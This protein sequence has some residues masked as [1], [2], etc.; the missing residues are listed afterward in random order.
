MF[1]TLHVYARVVTSRLHPILRAADLL[2][3]CRNTRIH[4]WRSF[5]LAITRR[6]GKSIWGHQRLRLALG[7]APFRQRLLL[8][9]H[10]CRCLGQPHRHHRS[11]PPLGTQWSSPQIIKGHT[12]RQS[13][14][15]AMPVS[16]RVQGLDGSAT[17]VT[18]IFASSAVHR[19]ILG[20]K[21]ATRC[22]RR[23]A[24]HL[25]VRVRRKPSMIGRKPARGT[26]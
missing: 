1:E 17:C 10:H 8:A 12:T 11:V 3:T 18:T 21:A 24:A 7:L 9:P 2:R 16:L 22:P 23:R 15:I 13:R 25:R 14:I 20:L 4:P 19:L 5:G 6:T 26:S